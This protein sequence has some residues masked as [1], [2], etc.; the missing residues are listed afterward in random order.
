MKTRLLIPLAALL[1]TAWASA[2]GDG[3]RL[4]PARPDAGSG[5]GTLP[6]GNAEAGQANRSNAGPTVPGRSYRDQAPPRYRIEQGS[7]AST[8]A[9]PRVPGTSYRDYSRPSYKTR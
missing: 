7:G 8:N 3:Y 6:G 9:F 2:M 5:D 4:D 1:I